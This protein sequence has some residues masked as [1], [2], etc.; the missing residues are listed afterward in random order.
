MEHL[1]LAPDTARL[2]VRARARV[3]VNL[4]V[5]LAA[6]LRAR[7]ELE[8]GAVGV[9]ADD[10]EAAAGDEARAD[11]EGHERAAA[12]VEVVASRL[13]QRPPGLGLHQLHEASGAQE[14]GALRAQVERRGR[15]VD[16]LPSR[17]GQFLRTRCRCRHLWKCRGAASAAAESSTC[18]SAARRC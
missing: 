15:R 12:H 17:D 10:A 13:E 11:R 8:D 7:L 4:L 2:R 9:R 5:P 16:E 1:E 14:L 6:P 18:R 3:W